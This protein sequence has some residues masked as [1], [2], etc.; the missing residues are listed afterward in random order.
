[1]R[2]WA[3]NTR[4][5]MASDLA[6]WPGLP[7]PRAILAKLDDSDE[8]ILQTLSLP[9]REHQVRAVYGTIA[10]GIV[11]ELG[12]SLE[13]D[14][15]L[16][17]VLLKG[18]LI[19][20]VVMVLLGGPIGWFMARRALRGVQEITRTATEI[21]DGALDRRVAVRAQG[22]EL[23]T[24]AR[25]FNTMIDRIQ[26]LINS[27][28]EMTDNLAHDLRSP[29][30]RMRASAEIS[31]ASGGTQAEAEVM[32]AT[33]AEECDRLLEMINT[34]LDIAEAESGAAQLHLTAID[35]SQVVQNAVE[36]FETI[37]EDKGLRISTELP[38]Y[39]RIDADRQR[40]QRVIANLLD[41]AL[42][43]TPDGGQVTIRLLDEGEHVKLSIADTGIGIADDELGRVFERFYRCERSRSE[44]G[45]GLGLSLAVAF[46]RAHEG[47][48]LA[49]TSLGRGSTFTIVLPRKLSQPQTQ[50]RRA[51]PSIIATIRLR[52]LAE[53]VVL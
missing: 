1:I 52:R 7:I 10:P 39:C 29:L 40:L 3:D 25:T 16:I 18:I 45:N 49:D 50:Q 35:L 22:D 9:Q 15:E 27:M 17:A 13:D 28:R 42:K 33:T 11:L 14:E 31:L 32:A 6:E 46:V 34:T 4:Q 24:L 53:P 30:G 26:T 20:L 2:L 8:P 51:F 47:D 44:R 36:L 41:N 5:A 48:I 12:E 38:D 19:A 43:Y 21:A 23:A 37:A